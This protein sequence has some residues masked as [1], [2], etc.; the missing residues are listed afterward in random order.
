MVLTLVIVTDEGNA[1][2]ALKA[3][4]RGLRASTPRASWSS[5]SGPAAR[6]GTGRSAARRRGAGRRRGGHRRDGRAAAARR[7][8]RPRRVGRAAAAAAGR[9]GGRA[10]GRTDAPGEPGDG[11]ARARSRSAG[12]PTRAARRGP[13]RRRWRARAA[14]YAPGDTDLAWTR[15]T[16][17]RSHAGRGAG[18]EARR[19]SRRRSV[20]GEATTRAPSCWR[21]GWRT[22]S[23]C[24]W[25]AWS[26]TVPASPAVR[27]GTADGDDLPRPPGRARWPSWRCPGQPDRH[28]ALQAARDRRADR[29]GAAPAR[30]GRHIP[31][32]GAV[33]GATHLVSEPTVPQD[34]GNGSGRPPRR[35]PAAAGR[36]GRPPVEVRGLRRQGGD[37]EVSVRRQ[38]VVHRDKELMA[39]GRGGPADHQGRG[40]P[41]GPGLRL[42]GAHRRPQRQ[43]AAGRARRVARAGRGGLGAPRPV[44]GRRA[45]PARRRPGAQRHPGAAR[46]CW[47]RCRWTRPGCT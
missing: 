41:G 35:S 8:G 10:G 21:C 4:E 38:V 2:D 46:R 32:H 25:S 18:P 9:A 47:T 17:W 40:R 43:R 24:R 44:V 16:P 6:R 45:V 19:R 14:A 42:G 29:R 1:Y 12:S 23:A 37:G 15:L 20:E 39:A 33:R 36:V 11:P 28:V 30:P 13:G 27:L 26:P 3:A 22:G 7:A 5:S 34:A 31:R